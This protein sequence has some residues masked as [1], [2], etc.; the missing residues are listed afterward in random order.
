MYEHTNEGIVWIAG[1]E[2]AHLCQT[3]AFRNVCIKL[4]NAS[5]AFFSHIFQK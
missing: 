1:Q 5:F 4:E 3:S 2:M